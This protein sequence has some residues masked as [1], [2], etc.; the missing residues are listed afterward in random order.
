MAMKEE[1]MKSA[2]L[3]WHYLHRSYKIS[4]NLFIGMAH[5]TYKD[6]KGATQPP[7]N[8]VLNPA[9]LDEKV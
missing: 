9:E 3:E 8:T 7:M 4:N 5:A 1:E 6:N 2:L